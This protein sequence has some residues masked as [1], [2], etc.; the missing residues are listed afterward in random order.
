MKREESGDDILTQGKGSVLAL[1]PVDERIVHKRLQQSEQCLSPSPQNTQNVL[2]GDAEQ[3]LG[4][5]VG[6]GGG[7]EQNVH[8]CVCL[9][10]PSSGLHT[11]SA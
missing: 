8:A 7:W 3:T 9:E 1:S 10:M 6:G 5:G 11:Q 4:G 2:T